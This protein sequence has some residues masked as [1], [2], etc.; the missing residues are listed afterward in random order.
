MEPCAGRCAGV[1]GGEGLA[2][3]SHRKSSSGT[4][5]LLHWDLALELSLWET[6]DCRPERR[7]DHT[8]HLLMVL[9]RE[10]PFLRFTG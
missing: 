5:L 6:K 9:G 2:W 3:V 10:K 8:V 1:L 4:S 7:R